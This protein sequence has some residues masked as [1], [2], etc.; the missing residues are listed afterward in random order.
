LKG[1]KDIYKDAT[2][3]LKQNPQNIN[4]T[5]ANRSPMSAILKQLT[6]DKISEIEIKMTS[7]DG[8]SRVKKLKLETKQDFKTAISF[9]LM[10][11]ALS[12]DLKAIEMVF[13]RTEGK[14]LQKT[15]NT[16]ENVNGLN[17]I[18]QNENTA[19]Q[20]RKLNETIDSI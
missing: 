17:I 7:E 11:K 8:K 5:G 4:R 13:D 3:G 12:G 6:D 20:I 10:Q 19:E 1:R 9:I 14:P 18:V 2:N 15:E 16:N